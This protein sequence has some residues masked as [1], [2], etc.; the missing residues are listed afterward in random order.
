MLSRVI[1]IILFC[2]FFNDIL[3]VPNTVVS[4]YRILL[5]IVFCLTVYYFKDI[6]S[7]ILALIAFICLL[8]VQN[9]FFCSV[10]KIENNIDLRWQ[11]MY[12]LHYISILAIFLLMRILRKENPNQFNRLFSFF[13][14]EMSY[15][16]L[17]AYML[18]LTP[19][20]TYVGIANINNYAVCLAAI[21]PWHFMRVFYGKWKSILI[22]ICI[23]ICLLLG[24]SKA[25][26]AGVAI[27]IG[28]I[29]IIIVVKKFK[30]GNK[31]VGFLCVVTILAGICLC[32]SP[33]EI[34]G[35][36][37]SDMF[38]GMVSHI[39]KG[40]LY[41]SNAS[42][43]YFRT[44]AIIYMLKGIKDT[45]FLG[46]GIGNTGKMLGILMTKDTIALSPHWAVLEFFCDCGFWAIILC[47]YIYG[48]AIRKLFKAKFLTEL[49]IFFVSFVL[50]FPMWSMSASGLYTTYFVFAIMAWLY[51]KSLLKK[52]VYIREEY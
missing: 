35:Y 39:I 42:S 48:K 40:E 2:G 12:F 29:G 49:D 32:L 21:F 5:L 41:E 27:E 25:A 9:M 37:I 7:F 11:L 51:E 26:L 33:L 3:R 19:Y 18:R 38:V 30:E 46:M 24:D 28:I 44:N 43:L 45:Y 36:C 6:W 14:V 23:F 16:Y 15:L 22:C 47:G 31:W 10:L 34:N 4:L 50:S 8:I 20:A 52:I 1:K 13:T 17:I